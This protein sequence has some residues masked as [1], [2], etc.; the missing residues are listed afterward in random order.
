M[1]YFS[2]D[3]EGPELDILQT[4]PWN[5]IFIDLISVEYRM[6]DNVSINETGSLA[7]LTNIRNFFK[8]TGMYEEVG[9]VPMGTHDNPRGDETKGLDVFFKRKNL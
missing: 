1:D 9:I 5:E 3:V 4:I 2:L 8:S 7:K 6:S